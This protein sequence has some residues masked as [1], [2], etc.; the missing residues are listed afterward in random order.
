MMPEVLPVSLRVGRP[1]VGVAER[2]GLDFEHARLDRSAHPFSGGTPTDVRITT[3]Y[4]PA[5]FTQSIMAVIHETGHALYERVLAEGQ[6]FVV[7]D[8]LAQTLDGS[9]NDDAVDRK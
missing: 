3:R 5:D 2:V 7:L 4:D 8:N 1:A 6:N 9:V